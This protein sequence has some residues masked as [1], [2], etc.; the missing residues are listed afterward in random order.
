M[1]VYRKTSLSAFT[2]FG[3]QVR[4][5]LSSSAVFSRTDTV[6]DSEFFYNLVID[7]LEDKGEV[8]EVTELLKWWNQYVLS[9]SLL[10]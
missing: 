3:S 5:A 10:T 9:A 7:L 8:V 4:F 2:D 1:H 6:T